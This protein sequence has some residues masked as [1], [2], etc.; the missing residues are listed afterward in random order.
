MKNK[1]VLLIL[2]LQLAFTHAAFSQLLTEKFPVFKNGE[3]ITYNAVYNWGFIWL[4]AGIVEFTV[5]ETKYQTEKKQQEIEL[6]N[7]DKALQNEEIKKQSIIKNSFIIGFGLILLI[8]IIIYRSF[9]QKRKANII[10]SQKN[11]EI[12]QQKEE[13]QAQSELLADTNSQL[14]VRNS[15]IEQQKEE[16]LTQRDELETSNLKLQTLNAELEKLSIV[17]RETDNSI[18]IANE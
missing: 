1:Y 4:N 8:A 3:T 11:T 7:K 17:A 12:Q 2:L 10:L 5:S 14:L 6:L 16:I 13:I 15:E 18:V 9:R